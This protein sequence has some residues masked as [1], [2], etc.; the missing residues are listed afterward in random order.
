MIEIRLRAGVR[1]VR[2][3]LSTIVQATLAAV[4]AY[5]VAHYGFGHQVPF[6]A[7]V[8]GAVGTGVTTEKRV[9]RSIEIGIGA[10]L[11]V[12]VGETFVQLFGSG[13]VQ[14]L[15][16][17]LISFAIGHIIN[18]GAIFVTQL[19]IQSIY[20][21]V[22]P[23]MYGQQPYTRTLDALIGGVMAILIASLFPRDPRKAPRNAASSML[24]EIGELLEEFADA[25]RRHDH[26]AAERLLTR[27]RNTEDLV[28]NWRNATSVARESTR[29]SP[30]NRRFAAEVTRLA[31]AA[32]YADRVMRLIRVVSRRL[33][34]ATE[35][36]EPVHDRTF[37]ADIIDD[38]S[39]GSL[40]LRDALLKGESRDEAAEILSD[41]TRKLDPY[42][43]VGKDL[44]GDTMVLLF[45]PMAV[46][47][48][49]AAG[50]AGKTAE[51]LLS[52]L[53]PPE[54]R[55]GGMPILDDP[56]PGQGREGKAAGHETKAAGGEANATGR[57]GKA[58]RPEAKATRPEGKAGDPEGKAAGPNDGA[59][60]RE[61]PRAE[62]PRP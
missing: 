43:V 16:V 12:L 13:I 58:T 2:V 10:T 47:L 32:D 24:E 3:N 56:A 51:G 4:L 52:P 38:L 34:G 37:L 53:K 1:R 14:M 50:M 45:R 22:V 42:R 18:G 49:Q 28:E 48:L 39:R 26:Q 29:I 21:V 33:V 11:G 60:R 36:K 23:V 46:D 25:L 61:D 59:E 5:A 20:V 62:P 55:T 35:A 15:I 40:V 19:G 27:A 6:L 17:M 7:A 9:R 41:A 8:A 54:E 44:Q 57:E 31:R 30:A